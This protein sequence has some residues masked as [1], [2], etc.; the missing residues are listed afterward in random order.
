MSATEQILKAWAV[1]ASPRFV[2]SLDGPEE[3]ETPAT[4]RWCPYGKHH[5]PLSD[6]RRRVD[7]P[8]GYVAYCDP[9][10]R[11]QLRQARAKKR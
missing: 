10:R 11:A 4:T 7:R 5:A 2:S 6:F 9:C 1:L 3:E 8:S